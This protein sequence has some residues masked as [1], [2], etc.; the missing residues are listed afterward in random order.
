MFFRD[1]NRIHIYTF[2]EPS[3]FIGDFHIVAAHL[4]LPHEPILGEC[5]VF[6]SV[7]PVPLSRFVVPFIPEL[8]GDLKVID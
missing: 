4:P 1:G 8:Y 2:L 7:S 6:E 3:L 5:P